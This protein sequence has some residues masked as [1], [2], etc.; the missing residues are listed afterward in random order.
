MLNSKNIYNNKRTSADGSTLKLR[1]RV[2]LSAYASNNRVPSEFFKIPNMVNIKNMSEQTTKA[3][4]FQVITPFCNKSRSK[5]RDSTVVKIKFKDENLNTLLENRSTASKTIENSTPI[6]RLNL[7]ENN[8]ER[9]RGNLF[10]SISSISHVSDSCVLTSN[11]QS[12]F[13]LT[14]ESQNEST[15]NDTNIKLNFDSDSVD[16]AI[17]YNHPKLPVGKEN[18]EVYKIKLIKRV[19]KPIKEPLFNSACKKRKYTELNKGMICSPP[20]RYAKTGSV[21]K[22]FRSILDFKSNNG[23]TYRFRVFKEFDVIRNYKRYSDLLI[24]SEFDDDIES[25]DE[26]IR[27]AQQKINS[28]L[29][30]AIREYSNFN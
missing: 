23:T 14:D 20:R 3:K 11:F 24:E 16:N 7:A 17:Y 26:Q 6:K 4:D 22:F 18:N 1:D 12:N 9:G 30:N 25:D 13:S 2:S 19:L 5:D 21:G 28:H 27:I 29:R 10:S 8:S 15:R